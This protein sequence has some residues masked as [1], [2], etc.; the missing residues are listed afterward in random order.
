MLTKVD[1]SSVFS[2]TLIFLVLFGVSP[3]TVG[4]IT[5]SDEA[6]FKLSSAVNRHN[7]VYYSTKNPH[8]TIEGQLNQPGITVWAG[9]S[10]KELLGHIF[11]HAT[12][13]HDL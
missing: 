3:P 8:V 4:K 1:R 11:I 5:W 6:H 9:L 2:L 7:S 13:T 12:V 10:C